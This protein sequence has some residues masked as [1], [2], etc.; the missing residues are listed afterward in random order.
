MRL[1]H[2]KPCYR[3]CEKSNYHLCNVPSQLSVKRRLYINMNLQHLDLLDKEELFE[4]HS[5]KSTPDN[6]NLMETFLLF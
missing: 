4:H 6:D 2:K 5:N 3:A 1:Q